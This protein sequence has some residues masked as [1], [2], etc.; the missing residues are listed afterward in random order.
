[1]TDAPSLSIQHQPER[2]RFATTVD[3]HEAA[4]DY[5][6]EG[7]VLAITHTVVP[8]AIGGRGIAGALVQAACDF[9]RREGLRVQPACSYAASWLER[10]PGYADLVA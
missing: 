7:D 3:S 4:L 6:R 10:H 2:A 1:M 5:E 8:A 9:A